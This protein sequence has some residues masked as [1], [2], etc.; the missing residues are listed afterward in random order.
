MCGRFLNKLPPSALALLF[1]TSNPSPNYPERFNIAPTDP[2]LAVRFN[3]KTRERTLDALRWG[4][5]P[6]WGKDLTLGA[7]CINA[8]GET[9]ASTPAFRDAFRS[10]RCL[11]P[12]SG[13][14]EWKREGKT[15]APYAIVP[16]GDPPV[17]AF[18]GLWENW[19]DRSAEGGPWIRTAA[20][21][22]GPPN[23]VVAALHNRMPVI[24]P[25]DAWA[26][27][28]GEEPADQDDL[29]A[30]A[31]T[32]FPPDRMRVYSVSPRVNSVKNDDPRLLDPLMAA[33]GIGL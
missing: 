27:W 25:P 32:P 31:L 5:V 19:R 2:I 17:F 1:R 33:G 21:V 11:I 23:A 24:L 26:R 14:Y 30:M 6:H 22:T 15:K 18:A 13:F 3:P 29:Q 12:A 20:I 8:R 9:L 28:V 7:R 10:R 16:A 4:L